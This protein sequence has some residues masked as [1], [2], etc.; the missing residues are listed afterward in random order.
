M[1]PSS[2]F[3]RAQEARQQALA[4]GTTLANA[5]HVA[6]LAAAAWGREAAAAE[7]REERMARRKLNED[8][9]RLLRAEQPAPEDRPFSES[10]RSEAIKWIGGW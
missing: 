5:K 6:T 3:C 1:Q 10:T 2:T 8:S 7:R 9:A 4:A